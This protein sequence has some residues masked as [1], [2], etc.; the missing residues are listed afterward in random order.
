MWPAY[1]GT[2]GG[3]LLFA[4][5]FVPTLILQTRRYGSFSLLRLAGAGALAVYAVAL[6]AYTLLP[7]PAADL[8]QWCAANGVPGAQTRPFQFVDDIRSATAGLGFRG[9]A[10]SRAVLQVVF[11]VLL[12]VPLGMFVRRYLG[13]GVVAATAAAAVVSA[14]I[15]ATQYT[16]VWGLI[17]CAYRVADVDDLITN[18][19]GGLLGAL[20][21]PAVMGWMPQGRELARRRLEPRPVGA[22]RRWGSMLTDAAAFLVLGAG[23]V[24]GRRM[25]LLGLGRPLDGGSV[26]EVEWALQYAV[27]WVVV[28]LV[29]ALFGSGASW[30]QRALWM[31]PARRDGT[32]PRRVALVVRAWAVGGLWGGLHAAQMLPSLSGRASDACGSAV[33]VLALLTVVSVLCTRDRRG[34]SCI[35][36]GLRLADARAAT[37]EAAEPAPGHERAPDGDEPADEGGPPAAGAGQGPAERPQHS[38]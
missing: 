36:T 4:A 23:L 35:L 2:V 10:T 5:V 25:V 13:R 26:E 8:V 15:E 14:L 12:F 29:P 18:T 31:V 11:N 3:L 27:P 37:A 19:V 33:T 30:G 24:I 6:V 9:F 22:W 20:L 7:L 1:I 38:G 17:G 34:L 32:R 21:A 28:F 16:G